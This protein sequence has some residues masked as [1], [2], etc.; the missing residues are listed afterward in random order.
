MRISISNIAWDPKE[1]EEI[2]KLLQLENV[3]AIDIAPG[4]YFSN[5]ATATDEQILAVKNWW[6][7]RGISI[8]GMQS[9]LFG[10]TGLNLFGNQDSQN[11]MLNHLNGICRI[12]SLVGA[13][14]L[15]FGSPKNRNRENLNDDEAKEIS[16]NF[17]RALG[18][19]AQNHGVIICLEPNP[20]IYGSNFMLDSKE[21]FE[22]VNMV[23]HNSIKMQLDTGAISINKENIEALLTPQLKLQIGHIHIS[24]PN[25]VALND[26]NV[27]NHQLLGRVLQKEMTSRIAT[28]EM[29]TSD[30]GSRLQTIQKALN[31]A[32]TYYKGVSNDII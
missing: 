27:T 11:S 13:K 24:E 3:D 26:S 20:A 7:E 25:L 1:D 22:V 23:N 6:G 15:V 16:I 14:L 30:Q 18:N 2:A 32:K 4:K 19:I 31:I 5:P 10:T 12:G 8:I 21:T 17:F 9:L 28:I 29:L